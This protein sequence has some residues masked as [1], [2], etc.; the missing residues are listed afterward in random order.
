MKITLTCI[1]S[2]TL[3][4]KSVYITYDLNTIFFLN[5]DY[6]YAAF[7]YTCHHLTVLYDKKNFDQVNH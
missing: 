2:L 1:I 5:L 3:N 6:G 7:K 4:D